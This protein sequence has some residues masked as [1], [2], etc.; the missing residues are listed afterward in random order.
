MALALSALVT[1]VSRPVW[2][3]G[4]PSYHSEDQTVEV[5]TGPGG[6]Q[7][8][9]LDTTL[10]LPSSARSDRPVPAVLLAHGLRQTKDSVADDAVDLAERGL[11]VLTWSAQG[12]GN[13]GGEIHLNSPDWEVSDAARLLD[14]LAARPEIRKDA[15]GDPRVGV[16]GASYGGA[17]ALLLAGY[18]ARVDAIVP[19]TT[20]NDLAN[21]LFPDSVRG[22]P[23]A[24]VFKRQWA[25]IMFGPDEED[26]DAVP[27]SATVDPQCGRFARDVCQAYLDMAVTGSLSGQTL[28]LLRRSSPAAVANRI[29]APTLLVQGAA[30][31]L[32]P[33][34][35]AD[36]TARALTA[37]GTSVRVAW[38]T[39]G[40][41]RDPAPRSDRD[42]VQRLTVEWL[43]HYLLGRGIPPA[44]EFSYSRITSFT[45]AQ[46]TQADL[47]GEGLVTDGF[48]VRDY[49]SMTTSGAELT[50]DSSVQTIFQPANGIPAAISA[51][52]PMLGTGVGGLGSSRVGASVEVDGQH[53]NFD[54]APL[55]VARDVVGS[56]RI[57]LRVASA[58]GKAVLFVKLYDVDPAGHASSWGLVAP[59][60]LDGLPRSVTQ[61]TPVTVPLPIVADRIG[62]GHRLRVTVATTDSAYASENE[63]AQYVVAVDGPLLMPSVVGEAAPG[64]VTRWWWALAVVLAIGALTLALTGLAVRRRRR[65]AGL[66]AGSHADEIP[67][68]ARSLGKAYPDGTVALADVSF[69]VEANRVVGLLG[70]NG[71]G[72]TTTMR[73]LMGMVRGTS[74]DLLVFGQ[75]VKPGA[76]VLCRV[77]ALVSGPGLLSHLSGLENLKL[78]WKVTGRPEADARL[79]DVLEV[80]GLGESVHSRVRTYSYGMRQR[81]GIAQAMLGMPDLLVLDE[82]V[83]GLDPQQIAELRRV[84]LAY[85]CDGRSVL[86][87]SHL[88]S[89]VEALCTDVVMMDH[90]RVVM[91]GPV[92]GMTGDLSWLQIEVSDPD[93]A[94]EVLGAMP[95]VG[96]VRPAGERSLIVEVTGGTSADLVTALVEAGLD[97]DKVEPRHGLE[98]TF[99]D[100]VTAGPDGA[101][102]R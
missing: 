70:R 28:A 37:A 35:E 23:A 32:F 42:R 62:A 20:W 13:S 49:P 61:A 44:A 89:E 101:A 38:F 82:P 55:A 29:Q 31:S 71:A 69:Q 72:K 53:A 56:P 65:R 90:G 43:D 97:I 33:L 52:A 14:W 22:D 7:S 59:V 40:H 87:S 84:L 68:V 75:T 96:S 45:T 100:L 67:L 48:T 83:N 24:G 74:G 30:D 10:Y 36:A 21:S 80:A 58:T 1:V 98:D 9:S 88:L 16:V 47:T 91:S 102:R 99:L 85:A 18:D 4:T 11:A 34:S 17:L 27:D 63:A 78:Y 79:S 54:S 5:R 8:V 39:G 95:A 3:S 76:P 77:G 15:P 51:L 60:R 12:F 50:L 64:P 46:L 41:D 2:P 94:A 93:R 26:T 19:M 6:S 92:Q 81:L 57:P 73:I 66:A 25:G 86:L